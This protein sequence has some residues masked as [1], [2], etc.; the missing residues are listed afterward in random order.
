VW[1]P[2]KLKMRLPK[3][4]FLEHTS[5]K[6]A[7][8]TAKHDPQMASRMLIDYYRAQP[9]VREVTIESEDEFTVWDSLGYGVR[10]HHSSAH[11]GGDGGVLHKRYASSEEEADRLHAAE[12][13]ALNKR[14]E[15]ELARH[16]R[17][18][19]EGAALFVMSPRGGSELRVGGGQARAFLVKLGAVLKSGK[20]DAERREEL[21]K[22]LRDPTLVEQLLANQGGPWPAL[23]QKPAP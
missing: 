7:Y 12:V 19:R 8:W 15:S 2:E 20:G 4:G 5:K 14:L 16:A 3:T 13:A 17:S 6:L 9:A 18:L 1:T 22:L 11:M 23:E 21:M 10:V